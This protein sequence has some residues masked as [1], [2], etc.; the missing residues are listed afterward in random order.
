MSH[1]CVADT[2]WINNTFSANSS[3]NNSN[4]HFLTSKNN[5]EK[6]KL[7]LKSNN[8][9]KYNQQPFTP[10]ELQEALE[11]SHNT[12]INPDEIYYEFLKHLPQNS[13]N[14]LL[15]ISNDISQNHRK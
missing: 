10:A 7:N 3:I 12:A 14:Y 1:K 9:E 5:A 11:T 6:Q 15:T 13:L 2:Y 4:P 8:S